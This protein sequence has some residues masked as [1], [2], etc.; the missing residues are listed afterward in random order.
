MRKSTKAVLLSALVFPGIGHLYVKKYLPGLILI[1]ASFAAIYYLMS[2]TV[3]NALQI[4]AKIQ[5]GTVPLD[6]EAINELVSAQSSGADAPLYNM[7]TIALTVC[8]LVGIFDAYRLG[9]E[10]DSEDD[11]LTDN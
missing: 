11:S 4:S 5:S 1:T 9:R 10:R 3:E 8:W 7:A 2:K 6:V